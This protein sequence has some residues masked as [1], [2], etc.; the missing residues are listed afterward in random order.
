MKSSDLKIGG[1]PPNSFF[2]IQ[3]SGKSF[4]LR[5][6]FKTNLRVDADLKESKYIKYANSIYI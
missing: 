3:D 1:A 5:I 6:I 4:D 2:K